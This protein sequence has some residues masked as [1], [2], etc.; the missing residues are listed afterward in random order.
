MNKPELL[1]IHHSGVDSKYSQLNA[2]NNYHKEKGHTLS[3]LG[4]FVAYHKHISPDGHIT[5]TR[6]D[7]EIG[8]H[9]IGW[10]DKSIGVCLD[11]NFNAKA[12]TPA[13]LSALRGLIKEYGLPYK[14]H[15]ELQPFRTCAGQYL[16]RDLIDAKPEIEPVAE[17][18][19]REAL[20]QKITFLQKLV[21]ELQAKLS[22]FK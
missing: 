5:T 4:F 11:G 16:T 10:N 15:K 14:F 13:Q 8:E 12:P 1:A 6:A 3:S 19:K 18:E 9:T 22:F 20:Q 2:I 17:I 21:W 7:F